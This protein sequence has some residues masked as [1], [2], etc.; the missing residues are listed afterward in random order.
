MKISVQ[1]HLDSWGQTSILRNLVRKSFFRSYFHFEKVSTWSFLS[2]GLVSGPSGM[3][4]WTPWIYVKIQKQDW[5]FDKQLHFGISHINLSWMALKWTWHF[6]TV[7]FIMGFLVGVSNMSTRRVGW[8]LVPGEGTM[9]PWY[10]GAMVPWYHGN[11]V[12]WYYGTMVPWHLWPCASELARTD[13][14]T[15]RTSNM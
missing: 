2:S 8:S 10:V 14:A 12:S 15:S 3:S 9:V 6:R 1:A 4:P 7:D 13:R 5:F 11:I